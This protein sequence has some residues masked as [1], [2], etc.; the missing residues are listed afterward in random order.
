MTPHSFRRGG[1]RTV[2]LWRLGRCTAWVEESA[3]YHLL[4][5]VT[6][7]VAAT[8]RRA[9]Y[10]LRLTLGRWSLNATV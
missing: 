5:T 10:E 2:K 1:A 7:G 6:Y 8:R 9:G 4:G 3:A